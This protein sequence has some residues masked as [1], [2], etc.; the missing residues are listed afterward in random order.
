MKSSSKTKN[1]EPKQGSSKQKTSRKRSSQPQDE[2]VSSRKSATRVEPVRTRKRRTRD[3]GLDEPD[4]IAAETT[5]ARKYV[6]LAPKTKRIPQ[7]VIETW[8]KISTPVLE[9]ISLMLKRAKDGIALSRRDPRRREE[10]DEVLNTVIRQLER[11]F[12]A[13]KIP[14]Q[15]K[16]LHFDLDRLTDRNEQIYREVTTARHRK[17]LLE[18]QIETA[19]ARLTGE[20]KLARELKENAQ[21][22]RRR[23]KSQEKKQVRTLCC[24]SFSWIFC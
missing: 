10:A 21:Q 4:E 9:Q 16:A 20:E 13:T 11:H 22:W 12:A 15:A 18:E 14:P 3:A 5:T 19:T 8:P 7:Q 23:W 24:S 17:Q 2:P 6:H 1:Q